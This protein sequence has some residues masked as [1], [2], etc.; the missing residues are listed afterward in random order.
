MKLCG[1]TIL[2]VLV[3]RQNNIKLRIHNSHEVIVWEQNN[4]LWPRN[5]IVWGRN[6]IV[7]ERNWG[8]CSYC[9]PT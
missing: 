8:R 6:I 7:C 5:I 4:I 1:Y 2:V 9:V 3:F